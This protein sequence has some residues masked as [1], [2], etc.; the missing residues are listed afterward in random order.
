MNSEKKAVSRMSWAEG[1]HTV[2]ALAY[3][4]ENG[5][6]SRG[7]CGG[8]TVYPYRASKNGSGF[9]RCT[10]RACKRSWDK[11]EFWA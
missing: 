7:T 1:W 11:I 4:V 8:V 3:L 9:D 10:I 5:I 6:I 2:G